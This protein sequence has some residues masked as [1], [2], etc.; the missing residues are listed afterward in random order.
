MR[1][2]P[3]SAID[4]FDAAATLEAE[5]RAGE[6]EDGLHRSGFGADTIAEATTINLSRRDDDP[7]KLEPPA[8]R[9]RSAFARNCVIWET[10]STSR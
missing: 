10:T 6:P 5:D 7:S 9:P 3:D 1:M 8:D 4:I 2:L